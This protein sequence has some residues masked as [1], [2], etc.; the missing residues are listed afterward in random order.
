MNEQFPVS[1]VDIALR[2]ELVAAGWTDRDIAQQVRLGILTK[3]RY[4]AYVPT[5]L[6]VDMDPV[7]L[8]RVRSR[9]VLRT[10][11]PTSVLSHQSALAE[12]GVPL[13]GVSLDETDLTRTDGK[14]GRR[15][16]GI[17]HHRSSLT[18]DE[19]TVRDGVPV[20]K[21]ARAA[22]ELI[23]A[24]PPEVGLV[25]ACGV[26]NLGLASDEQ[27]KAA[28]A[29]AEHWP[30]SLHA[31]IVLARA[32]R[33]LTSVAEARTWHFFHEHHIPRPEPQVEVHDEWGHLLGVVDFLWRKHGVFLEFDGR[34][35]Y[36]RFRREGES[37]EEYL[38]R[39]KRR[40]EQI[41]QLTG[42]VCIRITW[43]DLQ[44]PVRL[45]QRIRRLLEGR[46]QPA[47]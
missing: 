45:A 31:R 20:V 14:P 30:N 9:A 40:E 37:L 38:M 21:P 11:H 12:W 6:L 13:W 24:H 43:A 33:R 39:E 15:E 10:A 27:L 8:I 28:A 5:A 41:C 25:A 26:L 18:E 4:G 2:R 46:T 19:W 32:D 23:V 17:A 22:I 42:W 7:Q 44:N 1:L 35:K 16:A 29:R 36:V 3:V 47:A 34:I